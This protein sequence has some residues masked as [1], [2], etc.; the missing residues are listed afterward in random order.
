S[1]GLCGDRIANPRQH[2]RSSI[3]P[4]H[5]M[6]RHSARQKIHQL[7]IVVQFVLALAT[8]YLAHKVLRDDQQFAR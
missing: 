7:F 3:C 8:C 5:N 6:P 4:P 2:S 1:S